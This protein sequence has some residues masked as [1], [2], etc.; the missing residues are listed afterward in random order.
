MKI[1]IAP[2]GFKGS[3]T[4][5]Q[6]ARSIET[7]VKKVFPDAETVLVPA[8]DGGDGTLQALVDSSSGT[9]ESA[10]VS[11]PLGR[12]IEATWGAMGDGETAVIEMAGASGLALLALDE[13]DPLN[14]TTYGTGELFSAGLDAGYRRFIV[15]IGGSATNDGGAGLAQSLGISLRD[16]DGNELPR[17][18]AAL[19][20]IDHVDMSNFDDRLRDVEVT[21]ACDVNNP[22]CGE[23]GASAV[24]GPQKGASPESIKQLNAALSRFAD[25]VESDLGVSVRE[26][27]G[28]GAAGGLGAGLMAF[29]N[30][31]LAAGVDIVLDAVGLDDALEDADLVITGEGQIDH[32][33]IFNKTPVGIAERAGKRGIPVI[34]IAGG[35]GAGYQETHDKG[36]A[37]AFTLVSG[38]MTLDEAIADTSNLLAG[39]AEEIMRTVAIGRSL[40]P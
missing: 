2:Q 31:R 35:L 27:P 18:G 17:G 32:S 5:L 13:L 7:G 8:A 34:A 22:L 21:V 19:A 11:D 10:T 28:A 29:L 26:R 38:P 39:V 25:V 4:A 23:D 37:S 6:I 30:A 16:V 15:G 12:P 40:K 9:I 3:L 33:T 36:I 20:N 14:T 1:V 24:F